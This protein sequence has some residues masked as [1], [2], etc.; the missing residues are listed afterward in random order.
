MADTTEYAPSDFLKSLNAGS[1][2]STS[3][4]SPSDFLKTLKPYQ[5]SISSTSGKTTGGNILAGA[6]YLSKGGPVGA[7]ISKNAISA[8]AAK[9]FIKPLSEMSMEDW[10]QH[11]LL[12]PM[13]EYSVGTMYPQSGFDVEAARNKLIEKG[14]SFYQGGKEFLSNPLDTIGQIV[15]STAENPYGMAGEVVKS[16]IYDPEQ[17]P[18]GVVATKVAGKVIDKTVSPV[19]QALNKSFEEAKTNLGVGNKAVEVPV[20]KTAQEVGGAVASA[21]MKAAEG[22]KTFDEFVNLAKNDGLDVTSPDSMAAMQQIWKEKTGG[23]PGQ[24]PV[25][26]ASVEVSAPTTPII[27]P[28]KTLAPVVSRLDVPEVN[29]PRPTQAPTPETL[30]Q[31]EQLL[32][33]VGIE[34]MR[35]SALNGDPL[36]ASSQY[37]T[38]KSAKGLYAQGMREQIEHEKNALTGHFGGVET[39]LGG[40]VPRRGTSFEVS[41]EMRRGK[42]VKDALESAQEAHKAKTTELYDKASQEV[43]AVPVELSSLKD[44]LD[45]KSN[46]VHGP[47]KSLRNGIDSYLEEQGLLNAEGKVKPM[48]VGQSEELRKFINKQ[49]NHE[50]KGKIGELVNH[51]DDDVFKNVKGDT[52]EQARAH[53]KAGKEIY[54]N[55][56][57]IKDLMADEGVNQKIADKNVM[58]KIATIDESQFGHLINTL[59]DTGKTQAISEIQTALVNRIKEAGKSEINEPWNSRAAASERA[60]LSEKLNIAFAD[61]PEVLAKLDKGIQAGNVIYIPNKYPGAAVQTNLLHNKFVDIGLRKAGSFLG[62]TAG[63]FASAPGTG[64]LAGELAGEKISNALAGS[65]QRSILEKEIKKPGTPLKDLNKYEIKE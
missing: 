15:K 18:A 29:P 36:E 5:E 38:S 20:P 30:A 63:G 7:Y 32:K 48:T 8:D 34:N 50:T 54:D 44:Y 12:A 39:E 56:K 17:I 14:K 9:K 57:A 43:G 52:Y 27:E 6:E 16:T 65:K 24:M 62:A 10:K 45:K 21:E 11:S 35:H 31:T 64:A 58:N 19:V 25:P 46:F 47:E 23:V 49:Y 13:I 61:N 51:I 55:P 59:R 42:T 41:D 2:T 40:T 37:I 1:T 53:F 4:Y 60:K 26:K 3:E 33:D 22:P 28:A